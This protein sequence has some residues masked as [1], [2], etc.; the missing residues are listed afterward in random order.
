METNIKLEKILKNLKDMLDDQTK[1][2]MIS[3]SLFNS[4]PFDSGLDKRSIMRIISET[5]DT[6][7]QLDIDD[8]EV[9]QFIDVYLEFYTA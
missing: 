9:D 5:I 2:N 3:E 6:G 8:A 1:F 7:N 4:I